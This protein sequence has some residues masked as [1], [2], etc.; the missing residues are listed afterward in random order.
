MLESGIG[1]AHNIAVTTL[2]QFVLP[3]DTAGSNRYWERDI[4]DPEVVA[5]DGLITV[6]EKPGI[7]YGV[8]RGAIDAYT[9]A[10]ETIDINH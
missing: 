10:S 7:G 2:P 8:D 5:H 4:I 1:R 9:V 6:P 3:G